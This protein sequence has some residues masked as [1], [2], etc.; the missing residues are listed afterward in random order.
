[1][2]AELTILDLIMDETMN[3]IESLKLEKVISEGA[4]AAGKPFRFHEIEKVQLE[5]FDPL[6][7][8]PSARRVS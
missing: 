7:H 5:Y 8:I 6:K 1:M 4:E 2:V 3:L